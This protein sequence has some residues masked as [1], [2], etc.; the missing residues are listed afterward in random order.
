MRPIGDSIQG[1]Y[2]DTLFG[3]DG[4]VLF[5]SGWRSNM[6]VDRCRILLAAFVKADPCNGVL[7]LAVGRG[8]DDWDKSGAPAP[9][10]ATTGLE[11]RYDPPIPA[12][13][14][15]FVYLNDKDEEDAGP[16]PRL[17]ITATLDINYPAPI[18][19]SN[20]Y[21]LREFGLFGQFKSTEY[22]INCVRHPMI[23]KDAS[24][25]LIRV[26]RLYF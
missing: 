22:M 12:S 26:I 11:N 2:R 14:L 9:T 20:A 10:S 19:P 25:S 6:I 21:P 13:Q 1:R 7:R 5:E 4:R 23:P 24:T 18:P 15:Q 17:Q 16:T 8:R 3:P